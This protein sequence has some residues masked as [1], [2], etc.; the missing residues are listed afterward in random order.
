MTVLRVPDSGRVYTSNV[1]LVMGT[2]KRLQDVNTLVDVGS[3][4]SILAALEAMATGCGKKKVEQVVLTHCHSDHMANLA[5]IR[6]VFNPVVCAFSSFLPD[7]D[8]VLGDG[9]TLHLGD[10]VFEVVHTP[11]H[12]EDSICLYNREDGTLFVGDSPVSIRSGGGSYE[13]RFIGALERLCEMKV[14]AIYFGHGVPITTGAGEVLRRSLE[15]A[16]SGGRLTV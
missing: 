5:L 6:R 12:S 13:P 8:H 16:R 9:D 7:V 3:D 11:G 14:N 15:I 2:W 10:A 4:P 1:Y